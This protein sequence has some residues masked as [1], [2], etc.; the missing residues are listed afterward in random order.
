MGRSGIGVGVR[1]YTDNSVRCDLPLPR[2][3]FLAARFSSPN[4]VTRL[5]PALVWRICNLFYRT[6][7]SSRLTGID[8][9]R[10]MS[11]MSC[12]NMSCAAEFAPPN[13]N[14]MICT[15]SS[16]SH[17]ARIAK[18]LALSSSTDSCEDTT[19]I[20]RIPNPF[21]PLASSVPIEIVLPG[22]AVHSASG[23]PKK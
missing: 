6:C 14:S 15:P 23:W 9:D 7:E 10:Q 17:L 20:N 18:R 12:E 13:S 5:Y 11:A 16:K 1:S 8:G 21:A 4:I 22:V 2:L 19:R 3:F